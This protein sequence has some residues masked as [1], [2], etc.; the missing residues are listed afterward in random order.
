M[1][2]ALRCCLATLQVLMVGA[3]F[4]EIVAFLGCIG[5]GIAAALFLRLAITAAVYML[6][7]LASLPLSRSSSYSGG[8][9][10]VRG[11]GFF[12]VANPSLG[13]QAEFPFKVLS[14]PPPLPPSL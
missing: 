11:Q 7:T 3:K 5:A 14:P 1:R 13:I 4:I 12:L 8:W 9:R 10:L 6:R 2:S